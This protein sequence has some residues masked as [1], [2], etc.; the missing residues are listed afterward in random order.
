MK[1]CIFCQII[2]KKLP[3]EIYGGATGMNLAHASG[4]DAQLRRG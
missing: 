4:E 1:N 2:K 3:I